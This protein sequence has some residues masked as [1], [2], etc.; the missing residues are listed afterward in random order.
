M[1]SFTF[2]EAVEM[3]T[4]PA[5]VFDAARLTAWCSEHVRSDADMHRFLHVLVGTVATSV[6]QVLAARGLELAPG[7]FMQPMTIDPATGAQ[8]ETSP[9]MQV[10]ACQVNQD[11]ET[12]CALISAAVDP[13]PSDRLARLSG[14]LVAFYRAQIHTLNHLPTPGGDDATS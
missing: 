7:V 9:A 3:L 4:D 14:D 10:L 5:Y 13:G 12:V 11:H 1:S 2:E 8:V 6:E